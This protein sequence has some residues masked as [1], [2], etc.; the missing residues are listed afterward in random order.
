VEH[1]LSPDLTWLSIWR[2]FSPV[3]AWRWAGYP[4]FSARCPFVYNLRMLDSFRYG[5]ALESYVACCWLLLPVFWSFSTRGQREGGPSRNQ[6]V[7]DGGTAGIPSGRSWLAGPP[8]FSEPFPGW[9]GAI[10]GPVSRQPGSPRALLQT[11]R[12]SALGPEFCCQR[13]TS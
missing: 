12:L 5:A 6:S 11:D 9:R 10:L 8:C 4:P 7:S 3:G 1:L 13:R 2:Y